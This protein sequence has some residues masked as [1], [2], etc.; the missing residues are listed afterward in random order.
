M[1]IAIGTE[2][3]AK[4]QAV[5][6]GFSSIRLIT[7]FKEVSVPSG[8]SSQPL[9]DEETM[10]GAENRAKAARLAAGADI[11]IGLEGG[12]METQAGFFLCNWGALVCA[13]LPPIIAG[14]A[15]IQLPLEICAELVKG[16][17]LSPIMDEYS[18]SRQTGRSRGA[19]GIFTNGTVDRTEMFTHVVKLLAG[20]YHY[21]LEQN[22]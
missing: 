13:D 3:P 12:V 6:Q 17:E 4:V 16:R 1:I 10:K 20:R 15:R 19:M 11:G 22:S 21:E 14:G 8:V 7:D 9:T 18:G 5:K 2:N